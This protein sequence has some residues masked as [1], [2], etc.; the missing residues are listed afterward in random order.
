M[1]YRILVVDDD[2]KTVDLIRLALENEHF[3]A[4]EASDGLEAL[5][6]ARLASPD[7]IILDWMLPTVSG[8]D[9][10]RILRAESAVPVIMLPA[11]ATEEDN[12][13]GL[14]IGVDD[15]H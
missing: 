7:L 13:L 12:L 15:R 8:L 4:L 1:T 2:R 10:C 9:L 14:K 6:V 5:S 11:K 3:E